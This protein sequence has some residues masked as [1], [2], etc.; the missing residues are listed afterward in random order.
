MKTEKRCHLNFSFLKIFNFLQKLNLF[1]NHWRSLLRKTRNIYIYIY[2]RPLDMKQALSFKDHRKG[3]CL[4]LI[5]PSK[6]PLSCW[7]TSKTADT[8]ETHWVTL[9]VAE[10]VYFAV[11]EEEGSEGW[12]SR[13]WNRGSGHFPFRIPLLQTPK[14]MITLKSLPE[15]VKDPHW[16]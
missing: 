3:V 12:R 4:L 6:G 5:P 7:E 16:G 11:R 9:T 13:V 15:I 2:F 14:A 10:A 1:Q 8:A